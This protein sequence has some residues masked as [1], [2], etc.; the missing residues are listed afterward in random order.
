[1]CLDFLAYSYFSLLVVLLDKTLLCFY[2]YA[3]KVWNVK[4]LADPIF[5]LFQQFIRWKYFLWGWIT[6]TKEILQSNFS[7]LNASW[8]FFSLLTTLSSSLMFNSR[9]LYKVII[10]YKWRYTIEVSVSFNDRHQRNPA[11]WSW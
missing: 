6:V 4:L 2:F 5:H 9:L 7:A 8:F 3:F 10:F 1:M 11:K